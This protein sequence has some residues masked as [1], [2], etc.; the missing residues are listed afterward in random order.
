MDGWTTKKMSN[1]LTIVKPKYHCYRCNIEHNEYEQI[2]PRCGIDLTIIT[3]SDEITTDEQQRQRTGKKETSDLKLM[4]RNW[5]R[6]FRNHIKEKG[7][8]WSIPHELLEE[9]GTMMVPYIGRLLVE[10]YID[11]D[12]I[13]EIGAEFAEQVESLVV[14][15]EQ[16]EDL[17]RL[18][19]QWTDNEQ[20]IKEY[21]EGRFSTSNG[22][23]IQQYVQLP[24]RNE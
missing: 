2:C 13:I 12:D 20:E 17:L 15:L 8:D 19:G 22:C 7:V 11:N 3:I 9:Y 5:A 1:D 10:K 16:E 4:L 18:T 24:M 23:S 21:W 14:C 6:A